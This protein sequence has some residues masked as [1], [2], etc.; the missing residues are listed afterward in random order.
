MTRQLQHKRWAQAS[1]FGSV[2][3]SWQTT[4]SMS[5]VPTDTAADA[6]VRHSQNLERK[7]KI[8]G[9]YTSLK[10][11]SDL[12]NNS[13]KIQQQKK[14]ERKKSNLVRFG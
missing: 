3:S 8:K 5:D 13:V 4:H 9:K 7:K 6:M 14:K 1:S 11:Y 12:G 10:H 2:K